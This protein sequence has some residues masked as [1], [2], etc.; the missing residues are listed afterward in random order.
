MLDTLRAIRTIW[1]VA[2]SGR[3][4]EERAFGSVGK[5]R[6]F[7][8]GVLRRE[9]VERAQKEVAVYGRSLDKEENELEM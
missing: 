5:A 7:Y 2:A 3:D 9:M 4:G 1:T 8:L 6:R